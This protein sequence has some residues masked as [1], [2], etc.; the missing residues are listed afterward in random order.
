MA[1][2]ELSLTVNS[3]N[4]DVLTL[5][6]DNFVLDVTPQAPVSLSVLE[7]VGPRGETGPVGPTGPAGPAGATTLAALT[8]VDSTSEGG[9]VLKSDGDNSFSFGDV[10]T[11][12]DLGYTPAATT[13][14]VTNDA[15]TDAT[16]PAAT[17]TNAGLLTGSDKTK[18]DGIEALADVTDATNVAAAGA[19]MESD[20]STVNM[21]FVVDEDN[22]VSNSDTKVPTQQSVK[23]YVD[24]NGG[25]VVDDLTPQLGGDLDVNGN[26]IVSVSGGDIAITPNGDGQIVLDGLNWPISD[27]TDRQV[28]V[29]DGSG[30]LTF[31]DIPP[32]QVDATN[33]TGS[34]IAAGTPVYQ[35]GVSGQNITI[36][37]ADASSAS[38]MPAIGVTKGTISASGGTGVV[39]VS[40]FLKGIN[41]STYTA[42][43]TLYVADGGGFATSPP[44]GEGNLIENLGKVVKSDASAG[45]IIVTGA[46]RANATPNLDDGKIFIGNS[47]NQAVTSL[48]STEVGLLDLSADKIASGTLASDRLPDLAVS[49]FA[50]SAIVTELEGLS[51]SDNDTSLPTTAAVIDYV[52]NNAAG[53][54]VSKVGAPVD[55]PIGVWTGD[56]TIEG[57]ADLTWDGST[58]DLTGDLTVSGT[59]NGLQVNNGNGNDATSTAV[60][61]DALIN[62]SSGTANTAIGANALEDNTS[63]IRN[64]AIGQGALA[65]ATTSSYNTAI[66]QGSMIAAVTGDN[67]TAIGADSLKAIT[68]G[69]NNMAIGRSSMAQNTT[70]SDNAAV[71]K[72]ALSKN[73]TG[74]YN[75]ALWSNA[76]SVSSSG[77]V[78]NNVAIGSYALQGL[79][80]GQ[81]SNTALGYFAGRDLDSGTENIIIGAGAQASTT[82][83]SNEITFGDTGNKSFRIPGSSFYINGGSEGTT[84]SRVGINTNAP[85]EQLDVSGNAVVS[86]TINDLDI[87]HGS[88]NVATNTVVGRLSLDN[89]TTGSKNTVIGRQALQY[90]TTGAGTTAIG[91]RALWNNTAGDNN[92]AIGSQSMA[93]ATGSRNVGIGQGALQSS[94]GDDNLALGSNALQTANPGSSNTA[95]G[96]SAMV[97]ATDGS[98]NVGIGSSALRVNAGN[99]NVGLGE[100]ALRANTSGGNN[101]AIGL[102]AVRTT[103][104]GHDNI[105]IGRTALNLLNSGDDNVAIGGDAGD[106]LTTGSANTL[107]GYGSQA[108]TATV[109]NEITLGDGTDKSFRIPGSEFYINGGSEGSTGSRV[110]INTD[111]PTEQLD[112]NADA[113]RI[114]TAQTPASATAAG[115]AGTVCWDANYVYIC[116]ATNTWKRAAL[117]TW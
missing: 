99:N 4:A 2:Y 6:S 41:T 102:D 92:T 55:N 22:M 115:E 89:N 56:G 79:N 57:D 90:N 31:D 81:N 25:D 82:D 3:A 83:T 87:G 48:L 5:D 95:I 14:T 42:G 51:S 114:R 38:T 66:G 19:V 44:V 98:F 10:V 107:I 85:T 86:G 29:T 23:A 18:L 62:V 69:A 117:S 24:A 116:V 59:I 30:E 110:G 78:S 12:V 101:I 106:N 105:G 109:S 49:D 46:G 39:V 94:T 61:V 64:T 96:S 68:S 65:Q 71:G 17:T 33:N 8:D 1:K 113:I 74:S 111:A 70:G 77:A 32:V 15:G 80:P 60:G 63:G 43:D 52:A 76:L 73:T 103:T 13:G 91:Y 45:S 40:G 9:Q 50:G 28:L 20:T 104:V 84:G 11:A 7:L 97:N 108:S 100:D 53:G 27:G 47:G 112:V 16:I 34:T 58:F 54:D 37:P 88:G 36:A 72:S 26:S 21:S 35:T 75:T 67:N 93:N